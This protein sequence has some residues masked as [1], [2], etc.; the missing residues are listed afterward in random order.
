M[1]AAKATAT[2]ATGAVAVDSDDDDD[3]GEDKDDKGSGGG[4][5]RENVTSVVAMTAAAAEATT[6]WRRQRRRRRRQRQQKR[7]QRRRRQ[8][9]RWCRGGTYGGV[10]GSGSVTYDSMVHVFLQIHFL[11]SILR[12]PHTDRIPEGLK[13]MFRR[14]RNRDSCGKSATGKENTGIWR[15]P[16]GKGNLGVY[17][18]VALTIG[19][20]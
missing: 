18:H 8:Q 4:G 12:R 6:G 19:S 13:K 9:Q 3:D 7:Q 16:T 14:N 2:A 20:Y 1:A 11:R 15:I 5:K 10:R 17:V